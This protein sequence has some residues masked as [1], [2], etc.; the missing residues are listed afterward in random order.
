[1]YLTSIIVISQQPINDAIYVYPTTIKNVLSSASE[2]ELAALFFNVK[3]AA[4]IRTTLN[5]LGH[6]Q[7]STPIQ[8]HNKCSA[9]IANDTVKQNF[10]KAIDMRFYSIRDPVKQGHFLVHRQPGSEKLSDYSTNHFGPAHHQRVRPTFLVP[11]IDKRS[12]FQRTSSE[13]GSDFPSPQL[14][15]V[16]DF[17]PM[18][19]ESTEQLPR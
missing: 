9:G 15:A 8:T 4:A 5:E 6:P 12:S 13:G 7:P 17:N 16:W 10:S 11:T 18:L 2:V 19:Q 14:H 3:E 1:M